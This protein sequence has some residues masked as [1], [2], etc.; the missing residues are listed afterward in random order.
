V[1]WPHVD[2]TT[3]RNDDMVGKGGA[4]QMRRKNKEL[5]MA[6]GVGDTVKIG[7]SGDARMKRVARVI[8]IR[9]RQPGSNEDEAFCSGHYLLSI[10]L[11]LL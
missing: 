3:A 6:G 7:V 2:Q 9:P 4:S 5:K 1:D 11:A 10:V 8:S